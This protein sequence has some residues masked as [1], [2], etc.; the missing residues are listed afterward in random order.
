MEVQ[1][2]DI[3]HSAFIGDV[4]AIRES[5]STEIDI[6]GPDTANDEGQTPLIIAVKAKNIAAVSFLLEQGANP[7][8]ED[9]RGK[10]ALEYTFN[11]YLTEYWYFNQRKDGEID[12]PN[13]LKRAN[14]VIQDILL[15]QMRW[16]ERLGILM[17][18]KTAK[19]SSGLTDLPDSIFRKLVDIL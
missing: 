11:P 13:E 17:V 4:D 19:D 12:I 15:R 10:I 5:L 9:K 8:I 16:S 18:Y 6:D 7:N 1:V 14:D 3:H 2:Q